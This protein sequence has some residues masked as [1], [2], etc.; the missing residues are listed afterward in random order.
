MKIDEFIIYMKEKPN[1]YRS[2]EA[3]K[4]DEAYLDKQM[5]ALGY[6]NLKEVDLKTQ[7]LGIDRIATINN[8]RF[9][10]EYKTDYLG[11]KTN[12]FFFETMQT[13]GE[14]KYQGWA[15]YSQADYIVYYFKHLKKIFIF[16]T[17]TI[18]NNLKHWKDTYIYLSAKPNDDN[19]Q[20]HGLVIP[21]NAI[22]YLAT[23]FDCKEFS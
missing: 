9:T 8:L 11:H 20:A 3:N 1:F 18:K 12:N 13:K 4:E 23:I 5:Q 17:E 2:L 19:F 14:R 15:R 6:S 21:I 10:L 22:D 7:K 16:P